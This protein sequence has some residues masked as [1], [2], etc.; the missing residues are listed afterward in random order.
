MPEIAKRRYNSWTDMCR[1]HY[2]GRIQK[3]AIN[4][5]LGCPNRDGSKSVGGCTFCN[6][7]GFNPSYCK[8]DISITSQLDKGLA[9]LKK[10]YPRSKMFV[11]YFQAFSNTHAPLAQLKTIYEEALSHPEIDGL[12]IGTRPDCVDEEKLDYIAG[13]SGQYYVKI[14]YGIESCYDDTLLRINR[15][16]NFADSRRAVSMSVE[17]GIQTGIHLLFGLPGESRQ[18]MLDQVGMINRL[19][20]HSVK[21][22]Q[23]QIVKG[24][25]MALEY[26]QHPE[27]FELFSLHEYLEFL[28]AFI[29]RLRPDMVI[30]RFS[31]EVPPAYNQGISWGMIRMDQ[32]LVQFEKMLIDKDTWQG[33][34]YA[35]E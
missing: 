3:V 30:E 18:R 26:Q 1:I 9:F 14:E 2:G 6:N 27:R 7:E 11:A 23:L 33:R 28:V 4:A 5:G 12:V 8:P 29:E 20:A 17:R 13:L 35:G 34:L 19:P 25:A 16:H 10:R 31:G 22:H 15:G 21:F 24:T 32:V